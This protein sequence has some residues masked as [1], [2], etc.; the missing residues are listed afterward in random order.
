MSDL[1]SEI[2]EEVQHV[3]DNTQRFR[4][5]VLRGQEQQ[6]DIAEWRQDTAAVTASRGDAQVLDEPKFG[7]G[8]TVLEQCGDDAI[9][10]RAQQPGGLQ[11]GYLLVF[12]GMLHIRLDSGQMAPEG[13]YRGLSRNGA[14]LFGDGGES[15]R[16][17]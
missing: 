3:L 17:Q 9:D 14:A 12:E 13:A 2:P 1:K 15:V 4:R 10:Q 5:W 16:K 6:V 11:T 7:L 8:C